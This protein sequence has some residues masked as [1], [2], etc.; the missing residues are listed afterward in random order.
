MRNPLVRRAILAAALVVVSAT[1]VGAQ[2]YESVG[3]RAQGLGGAFV[4][5]ADDS[6]A[7]WWNPAGIATG[8]VF[9]SVLERGQ[10]LG[11][12]GDRSWGLSLAY[13]AFGLSYYR[14]RTSRPQLGSIAA[15]GP[16]RED[17]AVAGTAQPTSVL[18]QFGVT[19]DQSLGN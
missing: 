4:A 11:S 3:I 16:G 12:D 7:T 8:P 13:P 9:S 2:I 6:T 15:F 14:L 1:A 19:V 17:Q 10:A 5:V 18:S